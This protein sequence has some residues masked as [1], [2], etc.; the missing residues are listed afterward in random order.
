MEQEVNNLTS[1]HIEVISKP[2]YDEDLVINSIKLKTDASE[3]SFE[4]HPQSPTIDPQ[5]SQDLPLP[6]DSSKEFIKTIE[7]KSA[8]DNNVNNIQSQSILQ[9]NKVAEAKAH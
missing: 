9:N 5:A 7:K 2:D 3:D 1:R 6:R 4:A 8:V